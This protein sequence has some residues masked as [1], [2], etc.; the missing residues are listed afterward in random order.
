MGG[1]TNHFIN[2]HG[3]DENAIRQALD[4]LLGNKKGQGFVA[5]HQYDNLTNGII[6]DVIGKIH[7][8]NLISRGETKFAGTRIFLVTQKKRVND[9]NDLP[10]IA[11][12]PSRKFLDELDSIPNVSAMLV[13]PWILEEVQPW[14]KTW[15]AT[16]LGTPAQ[17]RKTPLVSN[18][19]LE[20]ALRSL[21]ARVNRST[22]IG[23]PSDR[24]AAIQMFTILKGGRESFDPEEVKAWLIAEGGWQANYAEEVAELARGVLE[25]KKF[26]TGSPAWSENILESWRE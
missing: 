2:T 5:V 6:G 1:Q 20:A 18:K 16:E 9:G 10:L 24:E 4:W 8:R 19:V 7:V 3:P 23:H 13:V 25:G 21:N 26:R 15:N 17:S 12:H 22:G 14:I 11:F